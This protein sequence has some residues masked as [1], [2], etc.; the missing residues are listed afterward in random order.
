MHVLWCETELL[1]SEQSLNSG[2]RSQHSHLSLK[3][4]NTVSEPAHSPRE[5]LIDARHDM[6]PCGEH[7]SAY[8]KGQLGTLTVA[9]TDACAHLFFLFIHTA[10]PP[11]GCLPLPASLVFRKGETE[12]LEGY[13][14]SSESRR[15]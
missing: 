10:V 14:I 9:V 12:S 3:S 8:C 4:R 7:S 11:T 6:K 15:M 1:S 5:C 2:N 13:W